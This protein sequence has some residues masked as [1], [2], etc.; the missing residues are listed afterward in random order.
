MG[1]E[2]LLKEASAEY[3]LN[4]PLKPY[5]TFKIGGP[6]DIM[7]FPKDEREIINTTEILKK[8]GIEYFF[9]GSGSNLLVSDKGYR[10]AVIKTDR[11]NNIKLIDDTLIE[12]E[13]GAKLLETAVFAYKNSL[14]GLEFSYGIPGTAGGAVYMNAGAYDGEM[15]NVV[16]KTAYIDE[17]GKMKTFTGDEHSFTYRKSVF[18]GKNVC[19][20]KTLLR[21]NKGDKEQIKAAMDDF[22]NRR[23]EKQPLN[24]P[25]AG[26]VFKRPEGYFTG[27]LIGD[28]GLKGF[29]VGGAK[30]SEKHS[31]FIVN[32]GNATCKDVIELIKIIKDRV[33]NSF[34]IELKCEIIYKGEG[35]VKL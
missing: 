2:G 28:S 19:I 6:A 13:S 26:S 14:S 5:T 23:E 29:A 31:G 12:A 16:A 27:R 10:G 9:M 11:L 17:N 18:T 21:L 22:L 32:T 35:E 34:G 24:M 4:E 8:N 3:R 25:S 15:K 1:I 20:I 7:I 30:V 33:Y